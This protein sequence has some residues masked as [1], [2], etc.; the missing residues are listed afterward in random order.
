MCVHGITEEEADPHHHRWSS[1]KSPT[2][3]SFLHREQHLFSPV[4]SFCRLQQYHH[5]SSRRSTPTSSFIFGIKLLPM[6]SEFNSCGC[7]SSC[8]VIFFGISFPVSVSLVLAITRLM[9]HLCLAIA[10]NEDVLAAVSLLKA[11]EDNQLRTT[12]PKV[13]TTVPLL[14]CR[15]CPF[16]QKAVFSSSG[17]L[18]SSG[19][20]QP[21]PFTFPVSSA[22]SGLGLG[23]CLI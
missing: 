3:S 9:L 7:C 5:N 22:T 6:Q 23:R 17:I 13:T 19:E 18:V 15:K 4:S 21:P 11:Q 14:R 20:F 1:P 10:V 8:L 16:A 12:T 2:P